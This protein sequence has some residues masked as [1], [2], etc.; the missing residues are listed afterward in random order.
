MK[1]LNYLKLLTLLMLFINTIEL[2][3]HD[4]EVD[5]IYYLI[6]DTEATVT[7]QGQ[8][9]YSYDNEYSGYVSIPEVVTYDGV[10]YIVTSI[11]YEAFYQCSGLTGV[12][13]PNSVKTINDLAFSGCKGLTSVSIPNSVESIGWN[14]FNGCTGLLNLY[15]GESVSFIDEFAFCGCSGLTS[16][17]IP[18]S[19]SSIGH[20]AFFACNALDTLNFNA[21]SCA[22]FSTHESDSSHPFY[23]VYLSTINI[24]DSVKR[25]PAYFAYD[26]SQLTNLNLPNSILEIGEGAFFY[27]Q[28]L[29]GPLTIPSSVTSIPKYAFCA[30]SGLTSIILPNTVTSIG[31]YAFG[32]CTNLTNLIIG[33]SV[34]QIGNDAFMGCNKLSDI[35]CQ[36]IIPP[37]TN[38][39]FSKYDATLKVPSSSLQ[40]YKNTLPWKRFT[41]ILGINAGDVDCDGKMNISDVTSLIDIILRGEDPIFSADVN[42]DGKVDIS[43][44]TTL[45]DKLLRGY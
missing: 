9:G 20:L 18:K 25:I 26:H 4:F 11:G 22:D 23:Q 42:G 3:A 14:A 38:S 2:N 40:D 1:N 34:I 16:V 30:C 33:N 37:T 10:D 41:N 24:G 44:V 45:I 21:I 15:I 12:E 7:H 17:T 13:I 35:I 6:N 32:D 29:T 43:D 8:Y 27:C 5:G 28:S 36:A 39:P 19:V 31:N